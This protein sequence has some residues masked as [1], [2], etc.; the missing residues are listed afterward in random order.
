[1][2]QDRALRVLEFTKIR[3]MLALNAITDAGKAECLAEC[4][5]ECPEACR[6]VWAGTSIKPST[7][8][9]FFILQSP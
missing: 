9:F 8:L 1:M 2:E 3:D 4:P 6:A 7:S 5:V